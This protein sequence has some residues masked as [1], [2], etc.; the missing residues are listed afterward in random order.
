M[1]KTYLITFLLFIILS[2]NK[3]LL[4][5]TDTLTILHVND[6]HSN[7]APLGPRTEDLKGTQGGIARAATVIGMNRMTESNVLLLHAGDVFIGDFFFNVYFG[8]AELQLMNALGFDAMTVGNHEFDLR[9]STLY[10]ALSGSFAAGE[11]F[12][13]LSANCILDDPDV[14]PLKDYISPYTIKEFDGFKVGIFGL[15]TPE[16]NLLSLPSPAVID[17]NI[18]EIAASSVTKLTEENCDIIILLSHLGFDLDQ[19]IASYVPGIDI[20][21]GGHDH[22]S[23]EETVN[24]PNPT[25][26]VT[27]IV[28]VG[29]FY[30]EMGKLK[31]ELN[32][33]NVSLIEYSLV[34]LDNAIPEES[35]I[36][37][38]IDTLIMGIEET[39]GPAYTQQIGYAAEY[40]EEVANPLITGCPDTP[41]GNLVTD[42]FRDKT[43]TDIAIEPGGSTAQP[44]YQGPLVAADVFR[45]LGYGFNEVNGLGFRLVTFDVLGGELLAGI[46]FGLSTIEQNDEFL[47]QV[48][49]INYEYSISL[50]PYS[51]LTN[52][53]IGSDPVDPSAT[54][55][56]TTNEF[57]LEVMQLLLGMQPSNVYLYE[58]LTEFEVVVDYIA[59]QGT[60]HPL[61]EC[62]ITDLQEE[63]D[64]TNFPDEFVLSQNYPNPFNPSTTIKYEIPGQ[65]MNDNVHVQ[66]RVYDILG[67][68][69]AVLVN[70]QQ[71]SGYY[72]I[73]WN[74]AELSSG[75]YLYQLLAGKSVLVKKTHVD[76][77]KL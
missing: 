41:V 63:G 60:I 3:G 57:V 9:P 13:L 62:R 24:V 31:F 39:Y 68:E 16:T 28:Q 65:A 71:K 58:D 21:I 40:F 66:L 4:A 26:G 76:E 27:P 46:E 42:A 75:I 34:K 6:T 30:S 59:S 15:T 23:I 67:R 35:T 11:G 2:A 69:V 10:G 14:Q 77:V 50:P 8:V 74:A 1:K 61:S 12:P 45:M 73:E 37:A 17:T 25:G 47:I 29:G 51:R 52:A 38:Q 54:Y 55:S 5:Q 22:Y 64:N 7:L 33:T 36:S 20:I 49:G 70:E 44:L 53:T 32:E 19:V 18:V 72:E 56:I 43:G 48:S